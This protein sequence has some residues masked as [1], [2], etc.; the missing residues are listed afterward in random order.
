MIDAMK[1]VQ[2]GKLV[3]HASMYMP[4]HSYACILL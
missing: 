4:V 3:Y 1:V 2:V